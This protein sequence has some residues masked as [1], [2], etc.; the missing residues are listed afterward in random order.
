MEDLQSSDDQVV[1]YLLSHPPVKPGEQVWLWHDG[2]RQPKAEQEAGVLHPFCSPAHHQ[3]PTWVVMQGEEV[4]TGGREGTT[5]DAL[6]STQSDFNLKVQ[7]V[8]FCLIYNFYIGKRLI[9][10]LIWPYYP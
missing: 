10:G 2:D 6:T 4:L 3:G 5:L 9:H 8:I 7:C 1:L